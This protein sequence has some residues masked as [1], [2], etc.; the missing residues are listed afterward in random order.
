MRSN[1]LLLLERFVATTNS[2]HRLP[3]YPTLASEMDITAPGQLWVSDLAY[4]RS[5][6]KFIYLTVFLDACWWRYLGWSLNRRLKAFNATTARKIALAKR[7][8]NIHHSDRGVQYVSGE[9][10]ILLKDS[11][12]AI[13][14][15]RKGNP[16]G[17]INWKA[18]EQISKP[19]IVLLC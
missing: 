5:G 19:I 9:Y 15:S 18:L 12:V 10:T 1:C 4:I 8:P 13:S 7:K 14:M 17:N 2:E 3:R 6:N 16:Y 11:G